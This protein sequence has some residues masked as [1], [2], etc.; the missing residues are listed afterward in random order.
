MATSV[1]LLPLVR[2][3]GRHL[4]ESRRYDAAHAEVGMAGHGSRF[5]L[6][7]ASALL[8]ALFTAPASQLLNE[9]LRDEEGFSAWQ[10]TVFSILTNT[11]GGIGLVIGGR[12]ADTRGRRGVGA[13]GVAAGTL[14]TV[15]MVLLGRM[16]DVGAVGGGGHRRSDGRAGRRRVR[17]RAVP[18]V[19]A[20]TGQRDDRD[21]RRDRQR[22]RAAHRRRAVR[23]WDGLGPA[24]ALLSVGPL[25]MALLVLIAYPE[26][27]HRELE[28]LNPED[29]IGPTGAVP[30]PR[31]S[32]LD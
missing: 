28:E 31:T 21:P 25:V 18:H 11:P 20:G 8:L 6:L 27:A 32:P 10:I 26:T 5:W 7:A 14:L 24:L 4:P 17:P 9:F 29:R 12:L 1:L 19:A 2:L 23:G 22:D 16:A 3:A 13:F 30:S 15:A